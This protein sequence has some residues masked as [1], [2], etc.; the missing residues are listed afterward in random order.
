[1]ELEVSPGVRLRVV[2]EGQGEPV[3]LLHGHSLDLSVFDELL[4]AL[5]EAGFRVIRYDQ[6][7]HGRSSSPPSGYRWGDNAADLRA[8]LQHLAATPAHVVG[9]SKGGGIALEAALRFPE[10]VRSLVLVGPLVPDYPLPSEFWAFF[11][12]FAQAIRE[13]G[14][15]QAVEELWLPHPLLRSAWEN[16]RCREKLE[17]MVHNFPAGEYL[18]SEKDAPDRDWKLTERVHEISCP[19]M[20]VRG[21]RDIP[22]FCQMA[23]FLLAH[24]PQAQSL[25]VAGCGHLV[26]VEQP[27]SLLAGLLPFLGQA[28]AAP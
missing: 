22:E 15:Q 26:P 27:K 25:V 11:K 3:V 5:V 23:D 9:L 14:V 17:T 2:V 18:A 16:P 7:G 12:R 21:E 20:V 24:I 8:V 28:P 6:R 13:K 4:P 10:I 19:V 1:M